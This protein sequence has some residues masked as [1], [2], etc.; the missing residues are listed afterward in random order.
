M[1][2]SYA[3]ISALI[4]I[5]VAFVHLA[6]LLKRWPVHVGSYEVPMSVSWFGLPVSASLAIWGFMQF[7]H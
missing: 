7:G 6:R 4:F 2:G 5:V 3:A 1:S